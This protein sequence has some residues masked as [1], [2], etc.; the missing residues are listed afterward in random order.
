MPQ[1]YPASFRDRAVRMVFDRLE[2]DDAL[3]R[4][5]VI[6]EIAPKLSIATETLRRWVEQA[7]VDAGDKPGV[8][9][10]AAEEIRRLKR[11]N[12]ELRRANEILKTASAFFAAELDRPST[13]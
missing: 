8:T 12:Q 7:E 2:D 1:K 9:S 6:K 10:S 3:S 4:Y 11:E 5:R 13:R